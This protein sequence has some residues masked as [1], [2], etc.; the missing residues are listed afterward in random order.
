MKLPKYQI[1][2]SAAVRSKFNT[3]EKHR[4]MKHSQSRYVFLYHRILLN[5]WDDYKINHII[6]T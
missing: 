4:R 5:L 6:H 3:V 1:Y 2:R